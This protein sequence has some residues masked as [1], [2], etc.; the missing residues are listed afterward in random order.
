MNP[1]VTEQSFY[2]GGFWKFAAL[3]K[4]G[5]KFLINDLLERLFSHENSPYYI[6]DE[7]KKE[8]KTIK[9]MELLR[10]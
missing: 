9:F 2:F 8:L 7:K 6:F 1:I 3:W 10:E 5:F 4:E